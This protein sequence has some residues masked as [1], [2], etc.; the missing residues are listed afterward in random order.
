MKAEDEEESTDKDAGAG[1]LE[2]LAQREHDGW[3]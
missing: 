1:Y 3:K 2:S